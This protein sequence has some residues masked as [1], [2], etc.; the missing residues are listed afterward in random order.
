VIEAKNLTSGNCALG[1][2]VYIY[3]PRRKRLMEK[4]I[5]GIGK[6]P[7][8]FVD[9]SLRGRVIVRFS[10]LGGGGGFV[11]RVFSVEG[12]LLE[13]KGREVGM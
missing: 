5:K 2:G 8:Q 7:I 4:P 1:T 12:G 10:S 9:G 3:E 13:G 6:A 11:S